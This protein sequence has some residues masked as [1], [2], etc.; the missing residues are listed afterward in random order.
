MSLSELGIVDT[1][2]HLWDLEVARRT[3][4][5]PELNQ[6]FNSFRPADISRASAA[7]GV[8]KFVVIEAGTTPEENASIAKMAGGVRRDCRIR[9]L[10][11]T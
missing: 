9:P 5:T 4:I 2:C 10:G 6:L 11:W 1:H 3:W 7:V 8:G